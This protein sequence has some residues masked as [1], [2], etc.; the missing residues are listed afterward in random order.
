M[1]GNTIYKYMEFIIF[2]LYL[3]FV[4]LSAQMLFMWVDVD[5]I[6]LK[7]RIFEQ[8][9]FL[10]NSI[11]FV[12][13]AGIFFIFHELVEEI[14]PRNYL[15]LEFLEL[16]TF[17]F[18]EIFMYKWYLNLKSCTSRKPTY[19]YILE[20]CKSPD[21]K[22]VHSNLNKG[23]LSR[24]VLLF[25]FGLITLVLAFF[26]PISSIFFMLVIGFLFIPPFLVLASTLIGASMITK[27]LGL[28]KMNHL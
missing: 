22:V 17:V 23:I 6:K 14:I 24:S 18:I 11:I 28:G 26:V 19:D 4:Y 3:L 10:R 15:N 7:S 1:D 20:A 8:G 16:L 25:A 21:T 27:E 5:K 13:L 12:F 9:T 2:S